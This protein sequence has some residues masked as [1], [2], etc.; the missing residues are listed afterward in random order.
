MMRHDKTFKIFVE[1]IQTN[2]SVVKLN[3][4]YTQINQTF[5]MNIIFTDLIKVLKLTFHFLTKMN[6]QDLSM[7]IVDHRK[8]IFHH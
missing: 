1:M 7:R 4:K 8:I 6:F 2:K 5:D 3:K